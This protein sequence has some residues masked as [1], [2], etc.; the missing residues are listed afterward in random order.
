MD[1][2]GGILQGWRERPVGAEAKNIRRSYI[3]RHAWHVHALCSDVVI[4]AAAGKR[5]HRRSWLMSKP[6]MYKIGALEMVS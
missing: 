4:L 1:L 3:N 6:R 5:L 2:L